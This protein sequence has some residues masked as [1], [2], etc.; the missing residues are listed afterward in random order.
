MTMANP[1]F[2]VAGGAL[3]DATSAAS[4]VSFL[5]LDSTV[6]L[7]SE[8]GGQVTSHAVAAGA[9]ITD[10]F[11][12]ENPRFILRGVTSNH[13]VRLTPYN[14]VAKPYG[15]RTKNVYDVLKSLHQNAS[16]FTLVADLDSYQNCVIRNFGFTQTAQK[17]E[18]LYVDLQIEQLR[19]V[20]S[21]FVAAIIPN[22]NPEV[23]DDSA[24]KNNTG[25]KSGQE[26]E[27]PNLRTDDVAFGGA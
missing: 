19:V 11:T 5:E 24:G 27:L 9:R 12:R 1:T 18:A 8:F 22:L 14:N 26:T 10:H 4:S 25:I 16:V 23:A 2:F 3:A 13:P 17:A 15:K 21:R 7:V 6:E 20:S